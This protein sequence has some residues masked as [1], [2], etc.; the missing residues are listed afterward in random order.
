[1][2]YRFG[3]R[4]LADVRLGRM[5][6]CV[7]FKLAGA[8]GSYSGNGCCVGSGARDNVNEH[9]GIGPAYLACERYSV[10]ATIN[11]SRSQDGVEVFSGFVEVGFRLLRAASNDN[12][13]LTGR[14]LFSS[15]W[16]LTSG[17]A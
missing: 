2:T 13:R 12:G 7:D 8:S 9:L 11:G 1:M 16:W 6:D 10:R 3:D 14:P 4:T 5:H 17:T 15:C